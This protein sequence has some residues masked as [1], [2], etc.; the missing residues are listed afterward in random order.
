MNAKIRGIQHQISVMFWVEYR[1][2]LPVHALTIKAPFH[3]LGIY[4]YTIKITYTHKYQTE[5]NTAKQNRK[6]TEL[7]WNKKEQMTPVENRGLFA[8]ESPMRLRLQ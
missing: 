2:K 8:T 5:N 4:I 3:R 6:S 7:L 1:V